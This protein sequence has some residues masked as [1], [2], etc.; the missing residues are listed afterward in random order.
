MTTRGESRLFPRTVGATRL[1]PKLIS[2]KWLFTLSVG[3]V[4]FGVVMVYSASAVLAEERFDSQYYFLVRQAMWAVLGLTGLIGAMHIDYHVYQRPRVVFLILGVCLVLLI[5]VFF[6]PPVN[7]VHRWIRVRSFSFQPSELARLALIIFLAAYLDRR[8]PAGIKQFWMTLFPCALV[9]GLVIGL[10]LLQPDFGT[11]LMLG[12]ILATMLF[13]VRVPLKQ[14]AT[15]L[16]PLPLVMYLALIR[17]DW[18]LDRLRAFLDPWQDPQGR[19]FQAIQ[20]LVAL[21]SGGLTGVGFAQGKQKLFFLP[22]PH[23]DFIFSQIGEELG[24]LGTGALVLAFGLIFWRGVRIALRAPDSFGMLLATGIIAS[25]TLQALFNMSVA[26]GLLPI[27][28]MP[29][30]L[31]SAGGSSLFMTLTMI[32]ILLNIAEQGKEDAD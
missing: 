5:A 26:V 19:G 23:T 10:I 12:L 16:I 7:H 20:S 31:I 14:Q 13:I 6:F 4:I 28:G 21:G 15:L 24:L 1:A 2:D 25:I 3:L 8:I 30:P 29:L 32:G 9:A 27:K 22:E 17:V 18:R 11:A